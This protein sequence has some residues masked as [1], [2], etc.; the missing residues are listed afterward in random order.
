MKN[1]NAVFF[2]ELYGVDDLCLN[3]VIETVDCALNVSVDFY[4]KIGLGNYFGCDDVD[5]DGAFCDGGGLGQ[6]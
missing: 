6:N 4:V 1:W 2:D 5:C 3:Q